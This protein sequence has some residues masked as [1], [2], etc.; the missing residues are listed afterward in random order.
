MD[1][2]QRFQIISDWAALTL[3]TRQRNPNASADITHTI[4]PFLEPRD[5]IVI[6]DQNYSSIT[7]S[8]L[9]WVT[10]ISETY[11]ASKSETILSTT[12]YAQLP[13]YDPRQDLDVA[14]IDSTFFGQPAI[15]VN[16]SYPSIDSGTVTTQDQI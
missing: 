3:L 14:T 12:A 5:P 6:A 2:M 1:A 15:N 9:G 16:I 13:S 7:G 4:L 10:R 11:E 8:T